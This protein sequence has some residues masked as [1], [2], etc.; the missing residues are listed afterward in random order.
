MPVKEMT[1]SH[2]TSYPKALGLEWDSRLDLMAPAIQPPERY[3]TTKRGVVSDVS[4]TFDILGWIAP[5]VL[6]MKLLY[7]QLWQLKTG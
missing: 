1:E 6:M 7:Q 4:K 2:S 5:A 3:S